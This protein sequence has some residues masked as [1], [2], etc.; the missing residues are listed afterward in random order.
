MLDYMVSMDVQIRTEDFR[1]DIAVELIEAL[2][3]DERALGPVT[4]ENAKKH[5]VSATFGVW[6]HG[7]LDALI[8]ARAVMLEALERIGAQPPMEVAGV[9]VVAY[10]D[11]EDWGLDLELTE[12]DD[13]NPSETAP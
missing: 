2:E 12:E 8:L 1:E 7:V 9:Q 6:A 13:E 11:L 3:Q 10:D 4:S 5:R